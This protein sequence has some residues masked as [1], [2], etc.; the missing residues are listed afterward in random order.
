MVETPPDT[1][2][3]KDTLF[4]E[5]VKGLATS[6]RSSVSAFRSRPGPTAGNSVTEL[7]SLII[8]HHPSSPPPTHAHNREQVGCL[9]ILSQVDA[10]FLMYGNAKGVMEGSDL[11][12]TM[13]LI[14]RK[15]CPQGKNRR[16]ANKGT[17]SIHNHGTA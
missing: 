10:I 13:E 11:Q 15:Q 2:V 12:V 9:I 17:K 8:G 7:D 4:T 1:S 5:A 3:P 14:N 16:A 6:V